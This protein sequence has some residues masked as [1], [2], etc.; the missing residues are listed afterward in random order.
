MEVKVEVPEKLSEEQ[1]KAMQEFA[2]ASGL[3][4]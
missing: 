3:K 1:Q 2:E 4:H